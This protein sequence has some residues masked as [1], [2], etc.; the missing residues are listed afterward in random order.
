MREEQHSTALQEGAVLRQTEGH[1]RVGLE[2]ISAI[3]Y[4]EK[5]YVLVNG[6]KEVIMKLGKLYSK[7][8]QQEKAVLLIIDHLSKYA[9][10]GEEVD[11]DIA[12]VCCELLLSKQKYR[13]CCIFIEILALNIAGLD[14]LVGLS[15]FYKR[16]QETEEVTEGSTGILEKIFKD[17]L[18]SSPGNLSEEDL[19]LFIEEIPPEMIIK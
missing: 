11:F 10:S 9:D 18:Q 2:V 16:T 4:Y 3:K 13:E 17:Y 1:P 8:E 7:V 6:Q 5:I 15:R 12:N 19:N 14:S